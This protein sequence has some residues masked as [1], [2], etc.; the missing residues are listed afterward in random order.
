[1]TD[2]ALQSAAT[3]LNN[4]NNT[5]GVGQTGTIITIK[6][7]SLASVDNLVGSYVDSTTFLPSPNNQLGSANL[8]QNNNGILASDGNDGNE[9]KVKAGK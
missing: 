5:V 2:V 1:L 8:V 4:T 9:G 7:E 3:P 6:Q